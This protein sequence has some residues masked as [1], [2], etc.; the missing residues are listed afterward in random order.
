MP[1]DEAFMDRAAFTAEARA[2]L[3]AAEGDSE[4]LKDH[5]SS[6]RLEL[7][8][9]TTI[10]SVRNAARAEMEA[11]HP[12]L[13]DEFPAWELVRV[14]ARRNQREWEPR[15]RAAGGEVRGGRMIALKNDPVWTRLSRF[16]NPWPPFDFGS[17]M[18]VEEVP[19][20]EAEK[21]GLVGPGFTFP[22]NQKPYTNN[23]WQMSASAR[24]VTQ[25]TID[26]LKERFAGALKVVPPSKEH[27]NGV[28]VLTPQKLQEEALRARERERITK[29]LPS[30]GEGEKF[31]DV[32]EA[33]KTFADSTGM[34]IT[35]RLGHLDN[36]TG[37]DREYRKAFLPAA[38]DAIRTTTPV[39]QV[40]PPGQKTRIYEKT[41]ADGAVGV[42]A[43]VSSDGVFFNYM[44]VPQKK[45]ASPKGGIETVVELAKNAVRPDVMEANPSAPPVQELSSPEKQKNKKKASKAGKSP[46]AARNPAKKRAVGRP[47][48][49][50]TAPSTPK[51]VEVPAPETGTPPE[52]TP[53]ARKKR[54]GG[55][56]VPKTAW[57][58]TKL[59]PL[60]ALSSSFSR[61]PNS[62][63][64]TAWKHATSGEEN[65]VRIMADFREAS[66][67]E[68]RLRMGA[69]AIHGVPRHHSGPR[70]R[71]RGWQGKC[72]AARQGGRGRRRF[73]EIQA[74]RAGAAECWQCRGS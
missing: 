1:A 64:E 47:D 15:W 30:L 24:G 20:E 55:T 56:L 6:S 34:T 14:E 19:R 23:M 63:P 54:A 65:V 39:I 43:V 66:P 71:S 44:D 41:F 50:E 45:K 36:K 12:E 2:V 21:L 28:I 46:S 27:P 69:R 73:A 60:S 22:R 51:A 26:M 62:A 42:R 37:K 3:G 33:N 16:G 49:V 61:R 35:T 5:T 52:K 4:S 57:L 11:L 25:E 48:A 72:G 38:L 17:G 68:S 10:E 74:M 67:L 29:L 18:G 53:L 7:I 13:L 59:T 32:V 8:Y 40:R 70:G 31:E 58:G 9:D